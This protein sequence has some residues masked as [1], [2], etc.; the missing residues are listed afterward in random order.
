MPTKRNRPFIVAVQ[1]DDRERRELK[2][3]ADQAALA[4]S[5]FVRMIA[6]ATVRRDGT[7]TAST[8]EPRRAA[9]GASIHPGRME[10]EHD[11]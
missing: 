1:L 6:L 5:V 3:A 11:D 10:L 9:A 7:L 2:Q 8:C 4:L